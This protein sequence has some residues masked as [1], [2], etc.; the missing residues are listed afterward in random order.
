MKILLGILFM[1]V[2]LAAGGAGILAASGYD[3]VSFEIWS[4]G[5]QSLIETPAEVI[6]EILNGSQKELFGGVV[7]GISGVLIGLLALVMMNVVWISTGAAKAI[8]GRRARSGWSSATEVEKI[9]LDPGREDAGKVDQL[10]KKAPGRPGLVKRIRN[11]R[12]ARR[13]KVFE[14]VPA[15]LEDE[16]KEPGKFQV[17]LAGLTEKLRGFRSS[18]NQV[19]IQ[20]GGNER[21]V[22]EVEEEESFERD[23]RHWFAGIRGAEANDVEMIEA[24][25]GL[26]SRATK[27]LKAF[28]VEQDSM[29]GEFMLRMLEA[30]AAKTVDDGTQPALGAPPK[31]I[32]HTTEQSVFVE[33]IGEVERNG[34]RTQ[35]DGEDLIP[36]DGLEDPEIIDD[37][38]YSDDLIPDDGGEE[39][40][41]AEEDHDLDPD[42]KRGADGA[43]GTFL[44][45][46][47]ARA[48]IG[49]QRRATAVQGG[50]EEWD[51][52]LVDE[53]LRRAMVE[54]MISALEADLGTE[55]DEIQV[56]SQLDMGED[57][58]V[59]EWIKENA[60]DLSELRADLNR[61]AGL[62]N[63]GSEEEED[64]EE[65]DRG[66]LDAAFSIRG[67]SGV[68]QEV[69]GGD[70]ASEN[71]TSVPGEG[72]PE[73]VEVEVDQRIEPAVIGE[74]DTGARTLDQEVEAQPRDLSL[75]Q[76]EEIEKSGELIYRWGHAMRSAGAAEARLC[77][78]VLAKDGVR[79]RV[80]GIVHLVAKWRDEE[81][82]EGVR[83]NI[84]LRY[85]PE[86]EWFLDEDAGTP[87]MTNLQGDFVEVSE[88]LVRQP[89]VEGSMLIVHFYGPGAAGD[90]REEG[91]LQLIVTEALS[92]EEIKGIV[93]K[94]RKRTS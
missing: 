92:A 42:G 29:N 83:I 52:D 2:L 14:D 21:V 51:E 60:S 5:A 7:A 38:D 80:V 69:Q 6:D 55:W 62:D 3:A 33:A 39:G 20:S 64:D 89:E 74:H 13:Q 11:W 10:E 77:H 34:V 15:N 26:K 44:S 31:S 46:E 35:D 17:F 36:D 56:L 79:R 4:L 59:F 85:L 47:K 91:D 23:L 50:A 1:G 70:E 72:D 94:Q 37:M 49:F 61:L 22:I 16:E 63:A 65:D 73:T 12:E 88:E 86:G 28:I 78:S 71:V 8:K 58:E 84:V 18:P 93:S 54:E 25:K 53:D 41:P 48:I 68:D 43:G 32:I 9:R 81:K 30:W 66:D 82:D 40:G 75:D 57:E 19:V 90:L 76:L 67:T 87:R 24:A 27:R 45:V